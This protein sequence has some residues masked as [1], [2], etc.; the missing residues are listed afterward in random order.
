MDKRTLIGLRTDH[1]RVK[2]G[3]TS[4]KFK[5]NCKKLEAYRSYYN[6]KCTITVNC[7]QNTKTGDCPTATLHHIIITQFSTLQG[8]NGAS[9]TSTGRSGKEDEG[10]QRG[11][12]G[13]ESFKEVVKDVEAIVDVLWV[14]GTRMFST[15]FLALWCLEPDRLIFSEKNKIKIDVLEKY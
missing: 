7:S 5:L 13:Y 10:E 9:T 6:S 2:L 14:S 1:A 12:Q 15:P 4:S 3:M 8:R 11:E